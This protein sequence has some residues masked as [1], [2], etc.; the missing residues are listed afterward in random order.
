MAEDRILKLKVK[1]EYILENIPETRNDDIL[2]TVKLW[3]HYHAAVVWDFAKKRWVNGPFD[4]LYELLRNLPREDAIKRIRAVIQNDEW[5]LLPTD[6]NV[7][8]ARNMNID[9]WREALGYPP[10]GYGEA[11][12]EAHKINAELDKQFKQEIL[13]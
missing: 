13:I 4:N 1:V 11:M 12:H 2:L 5:R 9:K 6:L 10:E 7:A 3:Q 8:K